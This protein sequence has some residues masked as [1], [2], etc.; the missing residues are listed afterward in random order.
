M[1]CRCYGL[2]AEKFLSGRVNGGERKKGEDIHILKLG[3]SG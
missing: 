1:S 2:G 3:R